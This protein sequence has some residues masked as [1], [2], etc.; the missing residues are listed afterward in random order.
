[1]T[2]WLLLVSVLPVVLWDATLLAAEPTT[3][4]AAPIVIL[5]L[6]DVSYW[7]SPRW[8]R[9]A[10]YLKENRI[11]ASF[12]IIGAGLERANEQTV[13]W[14]KAI[15]AEGQIEF[16]CHGY[17]LRKAEDPHGEFET[18]TSDEQAALLAKSQEVAKR[19]LGF[20]LAAFGPHWS[21]TT[22]ETDKALQATPQIKIWLYGP[23][24]PKH[25]TRLSIPRVMALENPTFVPDFDKF[26]AAYEK[27][28]SKQTVLVLQGHP[29]AWG[30]PER[31]DGFVKIVEFLR[32]QGC[33]FMTPSE[34]LKSVS[35]PEKQ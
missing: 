1:M 5:K 30:A 19:K 28:G 12:G 29:D 7:I 26:K 33:V 25:F 31:W 22:E 21:G 32:A 23:A 2:K 16:W 17:T 11:R 34:Y 10:D 4:P 9:V 15:H 27:A 8:I 13:T 24:K 35:T 20:E 18:G 14:I 3:R 6:D